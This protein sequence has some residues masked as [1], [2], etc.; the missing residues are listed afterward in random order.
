MR[1]ELNREAFHNAID[2]TLSGLQENPFLAQRVMAQAEGKEN[3]IVKMKLAYANMVLLAIMLLMTVTAF[4]LTNGFG[5]LDFIN[6]HK[7]KETPQDLEQYTVHELGTLSTDH[8]TV[9]VREGYYDG[10]TI[11]LIYDVIPKDKGMLLL[12]NGPRMDESW[13]G[14]THLQYDRALDDGRTILDRWNEGG[15]T[16]CWITDVSIEADENVPYGSEDIWD[17][18]NGILTGQIVYPLSQLRT[19]RTLSFIFQASP[20]KDI[21]DENSIDY[22]RGE[23]DA[24]TLT[25]NSVYSGEERILSNTEPVLMES[26]GAQIDLVRLIVLPAEIQYQINYS[27]TDP[28]KY[29][30]IMD[31]EKNSITKSLSFR[32]VELNADGTVSKYLKDGIS[33][34]YGSIRDHLIIGYLGVS[35][36]YDEYTLAVYDNSLEAPLEFVT[37]KVQYEDN[38]TWIPEERVWQQES[39]K[40]KEHNEAND[41]LVNPEVG[42]LSAA[43]AV[44]IAKAA[45]LEAYSLPIDALDNAQVITDLYVTNNRTDYRRWMVRFVIRRADNWLEREYSC[46]V[47][48]NGEVIEDPDINEPSLHYKAQQWK[49]DD[50]IISTYRQFS[51]LNEY[52]P[53]WMWPYEA[54]ANCS[55]RLK[56]ILVTSD[57][58]SYHPDIVTCL[59]YSFLLPDDSHIQYSNALEIARTSISEKYKVGDSVADM[60][61][62]KY[63]S[64][65]KLVDGEMW[66]FVLSGGDDYD[67]LH[68]F[69]KSNGSTGSIISC[70]EVKWFEIYDEDM[71]N[72]FFLE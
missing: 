70:D 45:I 52:K 8:F 27:V 14:I 42:D 15:F 19:D 18:A 53:F 47:D 38:W 36:L 17:E 34:S 25:L 41:T 61:Q 22:D 4:A 49:D 56:E 50:E 13:Y 46:I 30:S 62:V 24:I 10:T 65:V 28:E 59:K 68:Y 69:V 43:T 20:L 64:Y 54:K 12:S 33:N 48:S 44:S 11:H 5:L 7:D 71:D 67:S 1:E 51:S 31:D 35:E 23:S 16:S 6:A 40:S 32:F 55:N 21:H 60:L 57:D 9:N 2:E 72:L 37:V 39:D 58:Q 26:V 66:I 63:E 29:H 3:K